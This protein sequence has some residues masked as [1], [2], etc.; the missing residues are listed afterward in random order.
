MQ[1]AAADRR[2]ILADMVPG[3]RAP[4]HGR[5]VRPEI[6]QSDG[7]DRFAARLRE[8]RGADEAAGL[9]L[10]GA[11]RVRRVALGM[12][13]VPIAL[14]MGEANI[15]GRNIVLDI[16]EGFSFRLDLPERQQRRVGVSRGQRR[17]ARRSGKAAGSGGLDAR[18]G[19]VGAGGGEAENSRRRAR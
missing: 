3:D 2:E 8:H 18:P 16:D 4:G 12:L 11:H 19:A 15:L 13:D 6:R 7:G 9:A 14:A 17:G 5:R 10:I 1:G